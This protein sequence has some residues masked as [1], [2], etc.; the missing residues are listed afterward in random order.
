V[1]IVL[2]LLAAF[3]FATGVV[4]QQRVAWQEP[5]EHAA[6][7]RL[8]WRLARRPLWLLGM[9]ADVFAFGLQAI[10]LHH[11]SLVVVQPLLTTALL[12][13]LFLT[14]ITT[15]QPVV[16]RQWA[17]VAL[18]LTGLGVFLADT[19][20]TGTAGAAAAGER[21]WLLCTGAVV[22]V[23]A[24]A[25]SA[26]LRQAGTA[27]A[28]LFGVA[29][30][31]ADAF[32]ATMAKAFSDS[33]GHGVGGVFET[34]TPYAVV[35]AGLISLTLISTAYQAGHPTVTLPVITVVDPVVSCLIGLTLF[36]ERL[37]LG[38]VRGPL[39]P[40]AL[41]A[42]GAGLVILGRDDRIAAEVAGDHH[43]ATVRPA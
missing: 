39:L 12:F 4:L 25:V 33:F 2:S 21:A 42:M 22:V 23:T 14:S 9:G 20:P 7:P 5:E 16:L 13:T 17:A 32:M 6:K 1:T 15:Q 19:S 37:T 38:G 35:G 30:G 3:V 27:R 18:V 10:A 24:M 8:L 29:A 28:A 11:G 31:M 34:W 26:G 43:D 36:G 41:V 40:L